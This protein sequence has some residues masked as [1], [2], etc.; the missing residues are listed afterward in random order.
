MLCVP[1]G[2]PARRYRLIYPQ[3]DSTPPSMRWEPPGPPL[4]MCD[5]CA[6]KAKDW[7]KETP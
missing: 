3:P 6:S 7:A 4:I 5:E 1:H 2:K